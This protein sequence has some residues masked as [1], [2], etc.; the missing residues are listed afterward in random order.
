MNPLESKTIY[1]NGEFKFKITY[2]VVHYYCHYNGDVTNYEIRAR[3][4]AR[5]SRIIKFH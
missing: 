3:F 4:K 5:R 2:L 1:S